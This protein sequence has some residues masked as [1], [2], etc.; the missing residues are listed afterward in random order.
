MGADVIGDVRGHLAPG[1][2]QV[3]VPASGHFLQL[4]R[5]EAVNGEIV[6]FLTAG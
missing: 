6:R 3:V 1:S 4:E 2:E 5:P